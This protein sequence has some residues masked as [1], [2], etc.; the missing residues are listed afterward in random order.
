MLNKIL[1]FLLKINMY[2]RQMALKTA[3]KGQGAIG[4]RSEMQQRKAFNE[5]LAHERMKKAAPVNKAMP[6]Y[7]TIGTTVKCNLSC[8]MCIRR[9]VPEID[10]NSP[11][12]DITLYRKIAK[13]VFPYL[14]TVAFSVGG[15]PLAS[16]NIFE[17]MHLARKYGVDIEITTN[18][19]LMN[20]D[21]IIQ[22][23]INSVSILNISFDAAT[24]KTYESIRKGAIYEKVINNIKRFNDIKK[25]RNKPKLCFY[26]VLMKSNIEELPKWV[27]LTKQLGADF[28]TVAHMVVFSEELKNESLIFHKELANKYI[29]KAS[30][31]AAEFGINFSFPALYN[32]KNKTKLIN[33]PH[34][35]GCSFLWKKS[36]IEWN[37]DVVP[38][39]NPQRYIVG[40]V[41]DES[42]AEIWNNQFYQELRRKIHSDNPVAMC[43]NCYLREQETDPGNENSFILTKLTE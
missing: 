10:I 21:K 12:M 19:T 37:G 24:K 25:K 23:L 29:I 38:C 8:P 11:T 35:K 28:I 1:F 41:C 34:K 6:T 5:K 26:L 30:E 42:L 14:K 22:A 43:K 17:E 18:G 33:T 27:E 9:T 13:E 4:S 31:K 16:E 36:W 3:Y 7:L 15:E 40:N 32:Y 39:C 20:N 2:L